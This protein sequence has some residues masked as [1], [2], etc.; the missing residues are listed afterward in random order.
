MSVAQWLI[1]CTEMRRIHTGEGGREGGA[2][3]EALPGPPSQH[4]HPVPSNRR[5]ILGAEGRRAVRDTDFPPRMPS[6]KQQPQE[7]D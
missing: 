5:L 6:V 7:E 4:L 2:E 3:G 1:S